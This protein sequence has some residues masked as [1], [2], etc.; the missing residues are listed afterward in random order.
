MAERLTLHCDCGAL[1]TATMTH[2]QRVACSGCA[3][4]YWALQPER[5]GGLT[6]VPWPGSPRREP[7]V[8]PDA[9]H[10]P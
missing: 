5:G 7:E 2:Y 6:L 10:S 9:T 4:I 3:Q 8:H 1:I